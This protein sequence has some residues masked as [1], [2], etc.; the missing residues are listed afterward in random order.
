LGYRVQSGRYWEVQSTLDAA[1]LNALDQQ[2]L[3]VGQMECM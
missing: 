3:A 2:W 1:H